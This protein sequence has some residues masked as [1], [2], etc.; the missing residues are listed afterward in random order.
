M[1]QV[2]LPISDERQGLNDWS[3]LVDQ[4]KDVD[5]IP[6]N[7][8]TVRQSHVRTEA[9]GESLDTQGNGLRGSRTGKIDCG[10]NAVSQ[11]QIM[12]LAAKT[13]GHHGKRYARNIL[14]LNACD[15]FFRSPKALLPSNRREAESLPRRNR[16]DPGEAPAR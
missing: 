10:R 12:Y 3:F 16:P 14:Y 8:K 2:P 15:G 7:S 5:L 9:G 11:K 13:I 6:E 4:R 1:R